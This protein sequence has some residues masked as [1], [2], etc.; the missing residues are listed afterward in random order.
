M[1]SSSVMRKMMI[2]FDWI[3]KDYNLV[4]RTALSSGVS[5]PLK[6]ENTAFF[7]NIEHG[8]LDNSPNISVK[9]WS[10]VYREIDET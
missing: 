3:D 2:E 7:Q 8:W 6:R 10:L 9:G 5:F 4:P 1:N